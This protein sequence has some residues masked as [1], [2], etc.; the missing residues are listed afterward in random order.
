MIEQSAPPIIKHYYHYEITETELGYG[1]FNTRKNE[2]YF[3]NYTE[4]NGWNC[5]C[6]A[7]WKGN[8]PTCK[9]REFVKRLYNKK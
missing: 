3:V 1:I 5:T 9:H 4:Q 6:P 2:K 7:K 8:S